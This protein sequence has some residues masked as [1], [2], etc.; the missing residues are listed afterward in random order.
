MPHMVLHRI[1]SNNCI[2][3][4]TTNFGMAGNNR[5]LEEGISIIGIKTT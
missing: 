4:E 5:R 3:Y 1:L 2:E